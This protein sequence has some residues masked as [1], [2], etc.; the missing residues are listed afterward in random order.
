MGPIPAYFDGI[1]IGQVH[2]TS[3]N[4]VVRAIL[5]MKYFFKATFYVSR[6]RPTHLFP[7]KKVNDNF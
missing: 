7:W 3:T 6:A 5:S 2:Y 1:G 4:S